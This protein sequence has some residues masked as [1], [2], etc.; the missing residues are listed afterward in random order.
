M[1][2][3]SRKVLG[4]NVFSS[5]KSDCFGWYSQYDISNMPY[6]GAEYFKKFIH[7]RPQNLSGS[8]FEWK[9]VKF[10]N[11]SHQRIEFPYNDLRTWDVITL[12]KN[13]LKYILYLLCDSNEKNVL[14]H[15][16]SGWDR[17]PL[18]VS[19]IR[20]S[21]WADGRIHQNLDSSQILYLTLGYDWL[22]FNHQLA[23]RQKRGENIFGFCFYFL[24]FITTEDFSVD[25]IE[26]AIHDNNIN[27]K[28][29]FDHL[30]DS[31]D[32]LYEDS[33]QTKTY[34]VCE[35]RKKL[36][37]EVRHK[38]N[39]IYESHMKPYIPKP[40]LFSWLPF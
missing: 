3:E 36:L 5:E 40:S 23:H 37:D 10:F 21:L 20:L 31:N 24:E 12:T 33:T 26:K 8:V 4:F 28:E 14:I 39:D 9:D 35:R 13:Y 25:F 1:L 34:N 7:T 27:V 22:L 38:F 30:R 19:L 11:L 18:F 32:V 16:I 15:C 2:E 17:T 6:P 29:L